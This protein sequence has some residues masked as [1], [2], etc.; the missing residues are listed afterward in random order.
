MATFVFGRKWDMAEEYKTRAIVLHSI[1]YGDSGH[2]VYLYSEKFARVA[3]YVNGNRSGR[4]VVGKSKIA[5]QPLTVIEYTGAISRRG[6]LHRIYDASRAYMGTNILFDITKSTIALFMAEVI[7]K[8]I[9]DV[10]ANPLLY[11]FLY[12][13][14][15]ALDEMEGGEANFHLYFVVKLLD[16]LGY[17]PLN[18]YED[19]TFF[20]MRRGHFVVIPPKHPNYFDAEESRL[21]SVMLGAG[22]DNL[23]DIKCGR[24][25]RVGLLRK[26]IAY[27]G[28]HHET[29]YD[30]AS[31][32]IL[33]EIF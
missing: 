27:I 14:I 31:L 32:K 18:E 13:S 19:G 16:F 7:Y 4:P 30:I 1:K 22:V 3:C 20:D 24:V 11:D 21:F 5:L 33:G 29:R 9:R 28:L 8:I 23:K 10:D 26:I 12:S 15:T 2:I 25:L 6:E 17:K